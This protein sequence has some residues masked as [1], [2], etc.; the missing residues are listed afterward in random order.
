M[1]DYNKAQDARFILNYVILTFS[2]QGN[3]DIHYQAYN[4]PT[5]KTPDSM[6][7]NHSLKKNG[8]KDNDTTSNEYTTSTKNRLYP[9]KQC[10]QPPD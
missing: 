1:F 3:N 8:P 2:Q 10:Q 9:E 4:Y 7:K 5:S 6:A